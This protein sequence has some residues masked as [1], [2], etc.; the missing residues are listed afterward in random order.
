MKFILYEDRSDSPVWFVWGS[1][2]E[3]AVQSIIFVR[4]NTGWYFPGLFSGNFRFL[5]LVGSRN[6]SVA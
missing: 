6:S 5:P 3:T 4:Q 1:G 2:R